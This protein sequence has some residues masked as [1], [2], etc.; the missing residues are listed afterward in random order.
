[1]SQE[2]SVTESTAILSKHR[3]KLENK[4]CF[5]CDAKNPSWSSIP[6]GIFICMDCA[7]I[8]RS[9]GV[10][11]SFVRSTV[12]DSWTAIQLKNMEVGGNEKARSFFRQHGFAGGV[13]EKSKI[14]LKYQS[15]AAQQY[16][17][18]IKNSSTLPQLNSFSQLTNSGE[19]FTSNNE[20]SDSFFSFNEIKSLPNTNTNININTNVNTNSN[21]N[22]N[23]NNISTNTLDFK[24]HEIEIPLNTIVED[25]EKSKNVQTE[26]K[27]F[28]INGNTNSTSSSTSTSTSTNKAVRKTAA[29]TKKK[30]SLG[31]KKVAASSF[32]DFDKI[33][34]NVHSN[35]TNSSSQS[36]DNQS[37]RQDVYS[38]SASA[39]SRLAYNE[40]DY[41]N[42]KK[43]I[44]VNSVS[45]NNNSNNSN[46]NS[47]SNFNSSF[48][49]SSNYNNFNSPNKF[50]SISNTP[51]DVSLQKYSNAKAIS[52]DQLFGN[53][54]FIDSE[55][56]NKINRFHGAKAISSADYYERDESSDFVTRIATS[57][58]DLSQLTNLVVDGSKMFTDMASN[59]FSDLQN[60]Y[61]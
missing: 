9:L 24:N 15:R 13:T 14:A 10:H 3:A 52:S 16:R 5:D 26:N 58:G 32:D 60:R 37:T 46:T 1:M 57:G 2:F 44:N 34:E 47:N 39:S 48:S 22:S 29:S 11:I 38:H 45:N 33:E 7:A 50:N 35:K 42:T 27:S 56:K 30:K 8:H 23:S 12:F 36:S 61:Q 40:D 49:S 18:I 31:A 20:D 59:F 43:N 25:D 54:D 55:N 19:G 4:I 17:E 6:Y 53:S 51:T 21:T 41:T 28:N